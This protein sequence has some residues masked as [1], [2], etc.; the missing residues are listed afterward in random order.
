MPKV[1]APVRVKA[2]PGETF[3]R[4]FAG[5]GAVFG[6]DK[7]RGLT[8]ATITNGNGASNTGMVFEAGEP[9]VWTKPD[10]L[11]FDPN[12]PLPKLGGLFDGEFHVAFCDG[13]VRRLR[14]NADEKGLKKLIRYDNEEP[15]DI[16]KLLAK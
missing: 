10:D 16:D 13:S 2:K 11:P 3:Y 15:F 7:K 1:Y 14:K 9:V 6:P 8:M 4:G 5:E 12:K